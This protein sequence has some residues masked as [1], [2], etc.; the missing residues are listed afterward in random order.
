MVIPF[1]FVFFPIH[2]FRQVLYPLGYIPSLLPHFWFSMKPLW[3]QSNLF[4]LDLFRTVSEFLFAMGVGVA[5][6]SFKKIKT[7]S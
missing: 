1:S 7:P 3:T 6:R 2:L 4:S 5:D